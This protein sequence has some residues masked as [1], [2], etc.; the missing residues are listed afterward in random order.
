MTSG[1]Y[2]LISFLH[3][4]NFK[5]SFT[6][7]LTCFYDEVDTNY[8]NN[9]NKLYFNIGKRK[10]HKGKIRENSCLSNTTLFSGWLNCDLFKILI[11]VVDY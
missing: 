6:R 2:F 3:V 7:E 9:L 5:T 4:C 11:I 10:L 8:Q 1:V